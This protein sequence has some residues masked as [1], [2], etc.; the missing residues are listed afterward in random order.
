MHMIEPDLSNHSRTGKTGTKQTSSSQ[1]RS[2]P[3]AQNVILYLLLPSRFWQSL[4][5]G[6]AA[7]RCNVNQP[8]GS[9]VCSCRFDGRFL[10]PE[11]QEVTGAWRFS[12]RPCFPGHADS[13][14]QTQFYPTG[15]DRNP[16]PS[17][18]KRL[19]SLEAG[20]TFLQSDFRCPRFRDARHIPQ[21]VPKLADKNRNFTKH[22]CKP[23][24]SSTPYIACLAFGQTHS[25]AT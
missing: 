8:Y 21:A 13:S 22:P 15:G 7:V 2:D 18:G 17:T 14:L 23:L 16:T 19:S 1:A 11:W 3:M 12:P 9:H 6:T 5:H 20:L 10:V 25:C 4:N 24:R